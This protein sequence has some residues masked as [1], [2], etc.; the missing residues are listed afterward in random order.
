MTNFK[1]LGRAV[2]VE[3]GKKTKRIPA[4]NIQVEDIPDGYGIYFEIFFENGNLW[5]VEQDISTPNAKIYITE[6][7][8][9]A[10]NQE[11]LD[12]PTTNGESWDWFLELYESACK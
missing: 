12:K 4:V 9:W 2:E 1:D 7:I 3:T 6:Q 11:L 8:D 10:H 5:V